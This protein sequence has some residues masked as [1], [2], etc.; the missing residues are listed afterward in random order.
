MSSK[1]DNGLKI[2]WLSSFPKSGNT[3]LRFLLYNYVFGA[4]QHSNELAKRIPD[5]HRL[6]TNKQTLNV[7]KN[8]RMFVKTH[9][10][11]SQ[12]H[13]YFEHTERYIYIIRNPLDTMLSNARFFGCGFD[14]PDKLKA[15][16]KHYIQRT[17]TQRWINLGYGTWPA[18][19]GAWVGAVSHYPACLIRYEDLR[20]EPA[21][22]LKHVVRFLNL[23]LD[24]DKI[25]LA[26]SN[27]SID[28]LRKMEDNEGTSGIFTT[29]TH[30]KRFV[31]EGN[32]GQKI[33]D[34]DPSLQADFDKRF[35]DLMNL[36]GY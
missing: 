34:I 24:E 18:H 13:P 35:G 28:T 10:P 5:L 16:I 6:I 17:T 1:L 20:L 9:Y 33:S 25:Q 3:Y 23:Q 30:D 7:E 11:I 29:A 22:T 15:F 26:V 4:I 32:T 36:Y 8:R 19:I 2:T 31:N 27:S 14:E 21:K 12:S